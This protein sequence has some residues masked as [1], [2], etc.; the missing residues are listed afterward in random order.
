MT[1]HPRQLGTALGANCLAS[2]VRTVSSYSGLET[3]TYY[4][5]NSPA[6][7]VVSTSHEQSPRR[8]FLKALSKP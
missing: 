5:R 3:K 7:R 8:A 6:I 4:R 2:L 1:Q